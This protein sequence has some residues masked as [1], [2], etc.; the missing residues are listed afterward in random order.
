VLSHEKVWEA[1]DAIAARYSLSPSGL[2]KR[3]GLD[4]TA[5]NRSKRYSGDGRPRWPSTES[6]AKV[7]EA[8]GTSWP[9][10]TALMEGLNHKLASGW[11]QN[12]VA[13][14]AE[15]GAGRFG[16]EASGQTQETYRSDLFGCISPYTFAFTIEGEAMLPLYRKGDIV[17][18]DPKAP[19]R[20]GQR[21]FVRTVDG[22]VLVRILAR[23]RATHLELA[24]P[25][26]DYP[27][28]TMK[29]EQVAL[30]ARVIWVSQ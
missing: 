2:A 27:V 23:S 13:G 4:P 6:L 25:T 22:E 15:A 29:R 1:L 21:V 18:V 11:T 10:F 12:G 17:I 3:A 24:T 20:K 8:T 28:R 9:E 7:F 14:F 16:R 19:V 30:V 26:P 5:F